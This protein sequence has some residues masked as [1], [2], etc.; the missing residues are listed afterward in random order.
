VVST[1]F[2][3][4]HSLLPHKQ[5]SISHRLNTQFDC[6]LL[7][8][9]FIFYDLHCNIRMSDYLPVSDLKHQARHFH[10]FGKD[11]VLNSVENITD[12]LCVGRHCDVNIKRLLVGKFV[13]RQ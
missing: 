10:A 4:Y 2:L 9:E 5:L 7:A 8:N 6:V 1:L 12:I 13:F 3:L 11:H